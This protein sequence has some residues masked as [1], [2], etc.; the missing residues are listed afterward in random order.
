MSLNRFMG[1]DP[2]YMP[3][4]GDGA[5]IL[6]WSDR[7][8]GMVVQ[9]SKSGNSVHVAGVSYKRI[10]NNGPFTESQEYE[11]GTEAKGPGV[12]YTKRRNGQYVLKGDDMK[13]GQRVMLGYMD[14]YTDPTF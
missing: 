12:E 6:M 4:I 13:N 8:P 11:F 2:N 10:D 9:V 3:Q 5:T 1:T 14:A 7:R